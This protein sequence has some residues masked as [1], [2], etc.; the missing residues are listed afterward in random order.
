MPKGTP[1]TVIEKVRAATIK[2]TESPELRKQFANQ[3]T[4]IVIR[5]PADFRKVVQESLAKNAKVVEAVGL[6]GTR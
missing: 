5:G 2:A 3:A 6:K 1:P 4:E